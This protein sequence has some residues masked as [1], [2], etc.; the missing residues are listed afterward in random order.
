MLAT[1]S[2]KTLH[3][4]NGYSLGWT[5]IG[6]ELSVTKVDKGTIYEIDHQPIQEVYQHYL[7]NDVLQNLPSSAM[8]FPCVKICDEI[9]V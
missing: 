7:G 3:V 5:Q 9:E 1:L 4:N 8:E 6:K 2:G